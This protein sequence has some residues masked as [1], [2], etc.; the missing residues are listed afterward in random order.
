MNITGAARSYLDSFK[1]TPSIRK[2]ISI[3]SFKE[4]L[5]YDCQQ[6][7]L[8]ATL[9]ELEPRDPYGFLKI[10]SLEKLETIRIAKLYAR[11]LEQYVPDDKGDILQSF[12]Y[13]QLALV[14]KKVFKRHMEKHPALFSTGLEVSVE[15]KTFYAK[16]EGRQVFILSAS[17][18]TLR[19]GWFTEVLVAYEIASHRLLVI[20]KARLVD[21]AKPC[22]DREIKVLKNLHALADF[23][24]FTMEG[25]QPLPLATF[26][27]P[28]FHAFLT[29]HDAL[30][31]LEHI[32]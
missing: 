18:T 8:R 15:G 11:I 17:F 29:T 4:K 1:I 20:K 26:S 31:S 27:L 28:Y 19:E 14:I 23:D 16:V 22:I 13:V 6:G 25:M 9:N 24:D 21:S 10:N 30:L 5:K 32:I 3:I 7:R 12:N 2:F